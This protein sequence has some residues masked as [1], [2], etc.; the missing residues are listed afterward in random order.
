MA[1]PIGVLAA[2]IVLAVALAAPAMAQETIDAQMFRPS[3]FNGNFIAIEDA[4]TLDAMCY[5]FGLY[6][7]HANTVVEVREKDS[8]D[9]K[10][11]VL[12]SVTTING[13]AAFSPF[14]WLSL[15]VDVPVHVQ[16][17]AKRYENI[18]ISP[19]EEGEDPGDQGFEDNAALGDIKAELKLGLLKEANAGIGIAVAG[20][21]TFPTGD[22]EIFLGEGT[23]NF[24]GKAMI[25]K[26]LGIFNVGLNGGYLVRPSRTV[27]GTDISDAYLFGAGISRTIVGGLSFS[28]EFFGT[29]FITQEGD[30]VQPNPM[31]VLGFLRYKFGNSVRLIGGGGAGLS[32]GIGAP[33][34]RAVAGIDYYPHCEGPTQGKLLVNVVNEDGIPVKAGLK[35]A[36]PSGALAPKGHAEQDLRRGD[37][38]LGRVLRHGGPGRLRHGGGGAGLS[39]VRGERHGVDRQDDEGDDHA[40]PQEGADDARS[41]RS[42]QEEQGTHPRRGDS[43][44]GQGHR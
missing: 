22:E 30:D 8:S 9:F 40:G 42:L 18:E 3:I 44:E 23:T 34:Y 20:F 16:S 19:N 10:T 41:Q 21:G 37:R 25:E 29:S 1:R 15:G 35:V 13:T 28:I 4:H 5:G 24:G 7:N 43:R 2:L 38:G 12:N 33:A 31:E 17:R 26:D 39:P 32:S 36:G 27:F 11:G 6:V 14:S